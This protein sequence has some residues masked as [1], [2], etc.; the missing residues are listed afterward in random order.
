M[1]GGWRVAMLLWCISVGVFGLVLTL[2]A[3]EA[4]AGPTRMILQILG[5]DTP[6]E[7]TPHLKFALAVMGP[8]TLGWSL[9]LIG[10]TE[11]ARQLPPTQARTLWFWI[12]AGAMTWFIVDSILSVTT[13]FALN[14]VPNLGYG[15][16]YLVILFGSG[17]L[18]RG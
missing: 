15:I 10:A 13:G 7:V 6:L 2:G 16:A 5:G 4:T 11:A 9:T 18:K 17:V 12:T 3:I 8:V 1:N 14:V